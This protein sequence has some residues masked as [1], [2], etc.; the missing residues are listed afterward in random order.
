MSLH[1]HVHTNDKSKQ[2]VG[3]ALSSSHIAQCVLSVLIDVC[4][5]VCGI[6][7]Y[8]HLVVYVCD[9]QVTP[10][11]MCG[12]VHHCISILD[13]TTATPSDADEDGG[14]SAGSFHRVATHGT[15]ADA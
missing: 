1:T 3:E 13:P 12:V 4:T 15:R 10:S 5:Y 9:L 2:C 14:V 6:D 8:A 7:V 11:E